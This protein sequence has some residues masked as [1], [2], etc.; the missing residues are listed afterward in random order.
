M[1]A[2]S[3]FAL[4]LLRLFF[5]IFYDSNYYL[6]IKAYMRSLIIMFIGKN[7]ATG[8]VTDIKDAIQTYQ[9]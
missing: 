7:K 6:T 1:I 2:S 8:V 5:M 9:M 4:I 3:K